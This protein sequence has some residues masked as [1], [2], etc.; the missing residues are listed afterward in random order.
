[1]PSC[2]IRA[3]TPLR[4]VFGYVNRRNPLDDNPER[5]FSGMPSC[6]NRAMTPLREV[7]GYAIV[8]NPCNDPLEGS[9]RVCQQEES[10]R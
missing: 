6:R 3:M 7:L 8:Q 5:L 10:A 2:R 4:E 9:F 1:M